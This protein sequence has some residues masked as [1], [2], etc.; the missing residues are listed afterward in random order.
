MTCN[1]YKAPTYLPTHTK[2]RLENFFEEKFNSVH[3]IGYADALH[4]I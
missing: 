4:S 1:R 3:S 2:P